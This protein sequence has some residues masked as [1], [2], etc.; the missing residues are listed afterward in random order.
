MWTND[1]SAIYVENETEL[2]R[3]IWDGAVYDVE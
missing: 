1:T 2:S 3:L